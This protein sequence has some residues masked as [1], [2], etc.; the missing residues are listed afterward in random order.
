MCSA[1]P[2]SPCIA[3]YLY[4]LFSGAFAPVTLMTIALTAYA[5]YVVNAG[6]FLWK[7]R[8]ARLDYASAT[9]AMA[10]RHNAGQVSA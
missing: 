2:S 8:R 9:A 7:L 5:A 3:F 10:R 6:Q 4:G 1:L